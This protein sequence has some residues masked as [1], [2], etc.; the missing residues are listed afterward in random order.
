L[1]SDNIGFAMM[2]V[3]FGVLVV[4]A[5]ITMNVPRHGPRNRRYNEQRKAL[6][7]AFARE[8]GP[9]VEFDWFR[10]GEVP[11]PEVI[12]LAGKHSWKFDS[13]KTTDDGWFLR[14]TK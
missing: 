6:G 11:K 1:S 4:T 10:Y 5:V 8:P 13:E 9:T 7:E 3:S 12:I 2:L 14:F